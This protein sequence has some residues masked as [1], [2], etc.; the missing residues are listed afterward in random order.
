MSVDAIL[1]PICP[2]LPTPRTT[3]LPRASTQSLNQLD[4]LGK[5][6]VQPLAQALELEDFHIENAPGF[7]EIIHGALIVR[8]SAGAG[9]DS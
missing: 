7:S 9:K 8:R 3:T 2:D 6:L 5:I 1:F 4:G